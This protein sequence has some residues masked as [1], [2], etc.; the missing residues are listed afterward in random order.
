MVVKKKLLNLEFTPC[1]TKKT[2]ANYYI[3]DV[4]SKNVFVHCY[5]LPLDHPYT[6]KS[7]ASPRF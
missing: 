7:S 3:K 1:L 6:F 5:I 2:I 4:G